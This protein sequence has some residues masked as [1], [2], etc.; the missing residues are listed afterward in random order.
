MR[1]MYRACWRHYSRQLPPFLWGQVHMRVLEHLEKTDHCGQ[2][3][4]QFV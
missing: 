3:R 4:P 2:G 1:D